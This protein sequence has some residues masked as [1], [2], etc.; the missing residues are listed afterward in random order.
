[1]GYN[2]GTST[3]ETEVERDQRDYDRAKDQERQE[4]QDSRRKLSSPAQGE[5][6]LVTQRK[7]K[8]VPVVEIFGPTI[9]GEGAII[10]TQTMF[11]RF[12]LCDYKC[13]MCD[14][15]HAVDPKL[16]KALAAWKTQTEI[17]QDLLAMMKGKNSSHIQ[18]VTFSGGNPA[19]HD[20]GE[21]VDLLHLQ[22][23]KVIVETQGTK[24][25]DW[26]L[27][28]DHLVV[29]PKSPGMGEEFDP[30]VFLEFMHK[31]VSG[32][33]DVS[34]K[35]VVFSAQDLEFAAAVAELLAVNFGPETDKVF[36]LEHQFFLSLGNP[37]PP[38]FVKM[39][40]DEE[41]SQTVVDTRVTT[42]MALVE[43][44]MLR[45]N[46][47]SMEIMKDPRLSFARFLPQ[48]HVLVWGNETGK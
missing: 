44:L 40:D 42:K 41:E 31:I 33:V 46:L 26:L 21:L 27:S 18:N 32:Y 4:A 24:C 11:I 34:V 15:M 2:L 35:I 39:G 12:G 30:R 48:L 16:V 36:V 5:E 43:E 37:Q 29:S 47:L 19:I 38:T 28:V 7:T 25:P 9:E 17:A 20:L 1:M 14:S 23:K 13:K 3:D 45:Y 6:A 10:G 22:G 8:P